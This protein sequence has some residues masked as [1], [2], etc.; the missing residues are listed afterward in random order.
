MN[1]D[2]EMGRLVRQFEIK[3]ELLGAVPYSSGHINDTYLVTLNSSGTSSRCIL[4]RINQ[5]VF[6][7]PADLMENVVRVTEH[8]GR[9]L[10]GLPGGNRRGLQ[11]IRERNG[12]AFHLDENGGSWRAYRWIDNAHTRDEIGSPD[13][14]FEAARAFGQF[15]QMLVDLVG[16]PLNDTIADF[17][18]TPKRLLALDQVIE[19]DGPGRVRNAEQEIAFALARRPMTSVLIDAGL[20][21]RVTH[22]DAKCNNVL[23][24]DQTGEGI[25]VIDLDTVMAGLAPYDFGDMVRTMTSPA[26]EDEQDLSRVNMQ[27]PLFEAVARGYLGATRAFLTPLEK[28]CLALASRLITFEQGVRFLADY[29]AGDTYYKVHRAEQNLDRCRRQFKLVTSM[30]AQEA[31]MERLVRSLA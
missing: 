26:R 19:Q 13:Q 8:I 31:E 18:H 30:E 1:S 17:H 15:Q 12:R 6:P 25:C 24:D 3:G 29:L 16:P 9:K 27:M 21:E 14:A 4:Q 28:D 22:N 23:M 20:P 5:S 10:Y 7:N 2:H 11:L